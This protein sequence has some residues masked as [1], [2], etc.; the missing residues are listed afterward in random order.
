MSSSLTNASGPFVSVVALIGD[1]QAREAFEQQ[2]LYQKNL[3]PLNIALKYWL[4]WKVWANKAHIDE[5]IQANN[6]KI[7]TRQNDVQLLLIGFCCQMLI[8][9]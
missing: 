2:G 6:N 3:G 9:P 8:C 4:I 7:N 5:G 1:K